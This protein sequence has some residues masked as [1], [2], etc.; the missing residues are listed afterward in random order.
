MI[1]GM[2]VVLVGVLAVVAFY[3]GRGAG[4]RV[5]VRRDEICDLAMQLATLNPDGELHR[6]RLNELKVASRRMFYP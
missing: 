5:D 3:F 2:L 1:A 4:R 6:A